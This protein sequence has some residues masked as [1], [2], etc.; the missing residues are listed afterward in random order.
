MMQPAF[1]KQ[2]DNDRNEILY[3]YTS[4]HNTSTYM[5]SP[6][7]ACLHLS[8]LLLGVL[9]AQGDCVFYLCILLCVS[10]EPQVC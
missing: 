9:Y 1:L 10:S 7:S 8:E 3:R 2:R 4:T 5:Y 6:R